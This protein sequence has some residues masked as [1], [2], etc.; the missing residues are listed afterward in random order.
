M[1]ANGEKIIQIN[2]GNITKYTLK[3]MPIKNA[4][5]TKLNQSVSENQTQKE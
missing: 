2:V 4:K 1:L 5:D 3:N